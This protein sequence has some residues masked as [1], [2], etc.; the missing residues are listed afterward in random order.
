MRTACLLWPVVSLFCLVTPAAG[1][2]I[3]FKNVTLVPMTS[4]RSAP[5]DGCA[6]AQAS[7]FVADDFGDQMYSA[8]SPPCPERNGDAR[9]C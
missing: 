4:N 5:A 2:T 7:K 8:P 3:S 9:R 1:E 6:V